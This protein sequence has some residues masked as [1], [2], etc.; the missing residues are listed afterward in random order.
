MNNL[1]RAALLAGG[2]LILAVIAMF[3]DGRL[4]A[5]LGG[6][7]FIAALAMEGMAIRLAKR[8]RHRRG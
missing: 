8:H 7:A 2:G 6:A 5:F 3:I 4:G 1:H